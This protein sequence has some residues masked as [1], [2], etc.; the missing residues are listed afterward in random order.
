MEE[1]AGRNKTGCVAPCGRTQDETIQEKWQ[2]EMDCRFIGCTACA[3]YDGGK[4]YYDSS[5]ESKNIGV[6]I[7][8]KHKMEKETGDV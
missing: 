4:V 2:L 3:M 8:L 1:T 7:W 5:E 6:Q